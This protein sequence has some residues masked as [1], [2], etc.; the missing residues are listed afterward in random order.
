M[1]SLCCDN[2]SVRCTKGFLFWHGWVFLFVYLF[3]HIIGCLIHNKAVIFFWEGLVTPAQL[4]YH[5]HS[6]KQK[7]FFTV[8]FAFSK[9]IMGQYLGFNL[10]WRCEHEI[11]QLW[12]KILT[13]VSSHGLF[14][15]N[16]IDFNTKK[17]YCRLILKF[18]YFLRCE[19]RWRSE[20]RRALARLLLLLDSIKTSEQKLT[21]IIT[22]Q[23]KEAYTLSVCVLYVLL[24]KSHANTLA[25]NYNTCA[26]GPVLLGFP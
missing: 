5:F 18:Y 22:F 13:L 17:V 7:T 3:F 8:D 19:S 21:Q 23:C 1:Y 15:D 9:Q 4:D 26:L 24:F 16:K 2:G 11:V 20:R 12:K 14:W 25:F 6:S 10:A